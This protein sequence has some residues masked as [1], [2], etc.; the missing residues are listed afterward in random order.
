MRTFGRYLAY[1]LKQ[2][3]LRTLIFAVLSVL[4]TQAVVVDEISPQNHKESGLYILAIILGFLCTVIPIMEIA[5]YKNRRNL[6]ALYSFSISRKK[7]A[8]LHYLNGWIQVVIIYTVAYSH[9]CLMLLTYPTRFH[10]IHLLPYYFLSL[11]VG[12]VMY[13]VFLFLVEEANTESDGVIFCVLGIFVPVLLLISI[14]P[15]ID[16]L[17][18]W[19]IPPAWGC[20]Y[21]PIDSLT[22]IFQHWIHAPEKAS[23]GV[24]NALREWYIFIPWGVIGVA[25]AIGYF[26]TFSGK[27]AEVFKSSKCTSIIGER[28]ASSPIVGA[29]P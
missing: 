10:L 29:I 14:E 13:S 9:A 26:N 1:R 25:A 21:E 15:I 3:W 17:T 28:H 5:E 19:R 20:V 18:D 16:R 27:R 22:V 12:L 4:L 23:W 11:C 2:S 24:E 8:L 7:L 6:D